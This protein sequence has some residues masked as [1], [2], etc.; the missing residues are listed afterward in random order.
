MPELFTIRMSNKLARSLDELVASGRFGTRAETVRAAVEELV[1]AERRCEVG[2]RI[3]Q[4][5]A[6]IPHTD[7]EVA[8]AT[9]TAIPLHRG[10]ALVSLPLA[11]RSGS[12]VPSRPVP[13]V[14][15]ELR[16]HESA[17][18]EL[19]LWRESLDRDDD[20]LTFRRREELVL[21]ARKRPRNRCSASKIMEAPF[22]AADTL[23]TRLPRGG[24]DGCLHGDG[25]W[26][27]T[28]ARGGTAALGLTVNT[29]FVVG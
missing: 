16:H 5:Y 14:D 7:A 1:D 20:G 27:R 28:R 17:L 12:D 2:R 24:S 26:A 3:V 10:G 21:R 4:G 29:S 9:A 22:A 13:Q 8:A 18:V 6:D 11:V 23:A 19:L 25:P 15:D